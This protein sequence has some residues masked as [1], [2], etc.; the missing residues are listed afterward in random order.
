LPDNVQINFYRIAQEALN[1]V[2]K[3]AQ[4][5]QVT[6]SLSATP[7]TPDTAGGARHEVR[8]VI[9]DDGV[10]YASGKSR[11][12]RQGIGIMYERAAAIQAELSLDSQPGY[13]T[14][15]TLIWSNES[16]NL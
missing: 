14:Q 11:P 10:G 13:G 4:A 7:L 12:D 16:G 5:E 3:H 15:V 8:L 1:N 9:R 2:V 6:V